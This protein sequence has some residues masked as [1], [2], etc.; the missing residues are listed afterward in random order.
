MTS[1]LARCAD[2]P[3][4][5]IETILPLTPAQ[6]GLLFHALLAE[7]SGVDYEQVSCTLHVD[8]DPAD[9][10]RACE[11]A[12]ARHGVLRTGFLW[13]GPSKPVQ[14]VFY[15]VALPW[16]EQDWRTLEYGEQKRRLAEYLGA[17]RR[18][19]SHLSDA[20]PLRCSLFRTGEK[21]YEFFW[22]YHHLLLDSWSVRVLLGEVFELYL[23]YRHNRPSTLTPPRPYSEF[24]RWLNTRDLE[25][26]ASFWRASL[27]GFE[28]VTPLP[29]L[30][31]TRSSADG[32]R[33]VC[34]RLLEGTMSA[35]LQRLAG[36]C[37]VTPN[38]VIQA[39]WSLLLGR[40]SGR[41]DILFGTAASGR[42]AALN[43]VESMV[44]LFAN[45]LP[46]RVH[47]EGG[48]PLKEWFKR[49]QYDHAQSEAFSFMPLDA[50]LA[51]SG[52]TSGKPLFRSLVI[53]E[54]DPV[55][56][57]IDRYKDLMGMGDI[58][59][60]RLSHCP[61]TL[62]VFPGERLRLRLHFEI[63]RIDEAAARRIMDRL[64][65]IL[66]QLQ[67]GA[68]QPVAGISFLSEAERCTV[69]DDWSGRAVTAADPARFCLHNRFEQQ[70][71][72]RPQ[73]IAIGYEGREVSYDELNRSANRLAHKLCAAGIR[74]NVPVA[75]AFDRG[76]ESIVALLGVLKVG[77]FY[78]PLDPSYPRERLTWTLNDIQA[79]AVVCG[80]GEAALFEEFDGPVILCGADAAHSASDSPA[81]H[82]SPTDLCYV[83]YTSGSIGEPN[84]VCVEHRNAAH[85]FA[86]T[87]DK[88]GIG[89]E[90]VWTQSN[91][92]V[93]DF[94]VWEIWGALLHGGRLEIV[95]CACASTPREFL[96]RLEESG[97]TMLSQTPAAFK[98]LLQMLEAEGR[99]LPGRL[100]NIFFGGEPLIPRQIASCL[101]QGRDA[102]QLVNMYGVAETT[103][104]AT[105]RRLEAQDANSPC[106]PIGRPVAGYRIYIL[107]SSGN[108]TPVGVRGEIYVGGEGVSRGY[109]NRPALN[110]RRFIPDPFE[111]NGRLY[112]SGDLARFNGRGELEY[113]GR[114]D[115]QLNIRGFRIEPAE[116]EAALAAHPC[117]DDAAVAA[118]VATLD[119]DLRL[120]GFYVVKAS[121]AD[122]VVT[123]SELH[124][125]LAQK[126]PPY[127][128]PAALFA[129]ERMPLTNSGKPD[130]K[131][132]I[133]LIP[134]SSN[135]GRVP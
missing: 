48:L 46:T 64:V 6:Q 108:P 61:L 37:E 80:A 34:E 65:D 53:F 25:A 111:K 94:S 54:N 42:P 89:P 131:A 73:A 122:G 76:I 29:L 116:V 107:D 28:E 12:V 32:A 30:H 55:N 26:A 35:G 92:Y 43:G 102:P 5:T 59:V 96:Q 132:L 39:A 8:L 118:E 22:S 9:Y 49:L 24:L 104:H 125:W 21:R 18:T 88:Y 115:E 106:S 68:N 124:H 58:D 100:R 40:S 69:L 109:Y 133:R 47:I 90:D 15:Q 67:C 52:L 134:A 87:R 23:S 38:T 56:D 51:W 93:F 105:E 101:R 62:V 7:D 70:A 71:L 81:C 121:A 112:R 66:T 10:R 11:A 95:S 130:R 31:E 103:V 82:V 84:G 126:L 41:D 117:V 13:D 85:L 91:P 44:G 16:V 1:S 113:L 60:F 98:Q 119:G 50:I 83:I 20:P 2:Q 75:L 129:V 78:V 110:L 19:V 36:E 57:G 4:G 97:T 27:E 120:V 99:R 77:A 79:A 3:K 86:A 128:V 74:G 17:E 127:A 63:R 72:L 33:G 135:A 123:P 114:L 14:A 45:A